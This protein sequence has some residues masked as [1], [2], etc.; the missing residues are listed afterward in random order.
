[1]SS[2]G[3]WL[4]TSRTAAVLLPVV[5]LIA[6]IGLWWAA[7]V[8]FTIEPFLLPSPLDVVETFLE[9]PGYLLKETGVSLL[10]TM[11]GFL[12][13]IVVGV[14]IALLIVR[15]AVLER[16]VYPL[17]LGVNAI[18]KIA[19]APLLVV[20]MGFGMFPKVVMVLL[21][22]FFPVVIS[23]AT[24]MK[25]TP[26]E[27]VELLRSLNASRSQEYFKLRL[28]YAMPQIFTGLKVA[29]S[30]AVIGSVIA[31]FVGAQAGLGYVIS[32]S[33]QSADTALAFAAITLLSIMSIILFYGLVLLEQR[34]LPWA[35]ET[36]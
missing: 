18:P 26:V 30:L 1:M 19:I 17:L 31:E 4:T 29:I 27:L 28:T 13:A 33:G 34:L 2:R 22:C 7:T 35:Q 24:G 9:Q 32:S 6:A 12:L 11:G 15:S 36:R 8:V 10:E 20:W 14:P 25:S 23:T 21:V 16:L 5:G 3:S